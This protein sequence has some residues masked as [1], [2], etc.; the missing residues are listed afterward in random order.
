[1]R[2]DI[3]AMKAS[4]GPIIG[5]R[6]LLHDAQQG[7]AVTL[8]QQ[9]LVA[10]VTLLKRVEQE[11]TAH[12]FAREPVYRLF[13]AQRPRQCLKNEQDRSQSLLPIDHQKR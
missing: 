13:I 8:G 6:L 11:V 10:P 12:L 9:E 7:C 4:N 2:I 5:H 3:G 1:M